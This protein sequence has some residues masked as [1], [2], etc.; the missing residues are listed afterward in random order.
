MNFQNM[1]PPDIKMPES[2]QQASES[3][4]NSITDM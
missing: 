2:I 3:F 4:G 1:A